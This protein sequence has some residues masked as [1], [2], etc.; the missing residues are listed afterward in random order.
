MA[1]YVPDISSHRWVILSSTRAN[2]PNNHQVKHTKDPFAQGNEDATSQE[3]LRIGEGGPAEPGW[4]VRVVSNKFPITDMHEVVVHSP[5]PKKNIEDLPVEQV[6]HILEAYIQR[7]NHYHDTGQVMIFCNSGEHAGASIKHPHSQIVVIPPQINPD[8][9]NR[10]P[11]NNTVLE[12]KNFHAYCPDFSQWPYELWITPFESESRFGDLDGTCRHELACILKN[13]LQRLHSIYKKEKFTSEFAYNYYISPRQNWYLRII[14]RFVH[15]AGF[16]LG[17]G[18]SVNV[19]DPIDAA[20]AYQ[21]VESRYHE[22]VSHL[23]Q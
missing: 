18:L 10:E 23:K 8:S 11:I 16:E 21:G 22:L 13:M 19:I 12:T 15:R 9:L 3:V 2:R 1:K 5:D 6:D 20:L 17:T 14:P 7:S 4:K